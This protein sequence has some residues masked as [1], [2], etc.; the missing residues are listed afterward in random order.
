MLSTELLHVALR[1]R[2]NVRAEAAGALAVAERDLRMLRRPPANHVSA[3]APRS[4]VVR[5]VPSRVVAEFGRSDADQLTD[6]TLVQRER[7]AS[8]SGRGA[9]LERQIRAAVA[10]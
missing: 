3:T 9:L 4:S 1:E 7:S 5:R 6:W 8:S 10:A 2:E